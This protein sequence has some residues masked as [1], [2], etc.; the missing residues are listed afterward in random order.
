MKC[1]LLR[2]HVGHDISCETQL[3]ESV[4]L[5]SVGHPVLQSS[6][7]PSF[8]L[9]VLTHCVTAH[10]C[11]PATARNLESDCVMI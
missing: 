11:A 7:C 8:S 6:L 9:S 10:T 1:F 2:F 4:S 3:L 5:N